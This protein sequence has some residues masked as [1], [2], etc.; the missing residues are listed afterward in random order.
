[1]ACLF[2]CLHWMPF[3]L[4]VQFSHGQGIIR[5]NEKKNEKCTNEVEYVRET[6]RL[7]LSLHL[8]GELL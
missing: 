1:M 2:A 5:M 4:N 7:M 3:S 6:L 8:Q